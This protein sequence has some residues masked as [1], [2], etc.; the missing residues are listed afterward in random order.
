MSTVWK[1]INPSKFIKSRYTLKR[2][3]SGTKDRVFLV[4]VLWEVEF[5]PWDCREGFLN[6]APQ[7]FTNWLWP[8]EMIVSTRPTT[9]QEF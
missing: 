7:S 4:S 5:C 6:D 9:S 2:Q 3:G 8:L 1:P